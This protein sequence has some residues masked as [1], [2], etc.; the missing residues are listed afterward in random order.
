MNKVIYIYI[1]MKIWEII[2]LN[3]QNDYTKS[4]ILKLL[5]EAITQASS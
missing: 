3:N 4:V 1:Y 2:G 5:M